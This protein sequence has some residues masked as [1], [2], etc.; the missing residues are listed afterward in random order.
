M[1]AQSLFYIGVIL[2]LIGG[3]VLTLI[4]VKVKS[5]FSSTEVR[6]LR[7]EVM[8]LEKR[9]HEIDRYIDEMIGHAEK[10]A[11]SFSAQKSADKNH[12]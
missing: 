1:D 5:L 6:K 8:D 10:L 9:L 4:V 11:H 12:S 3:I 7:R 2:G